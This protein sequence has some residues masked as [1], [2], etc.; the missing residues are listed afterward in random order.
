MGPFF[1][2]SNMPTDGPPS[3]AVR[4]NSSTLPNSFTA[5][6]EIQYDPSGRYQKSTTHI[7]QS[8]GIR[9][10]YKA[11]DTETALE[12][13]WQEY[14]GVSVSSMNAIEKSI[15][16]LKSLNHK[17]IIKYHEGWVDRKQKKVI[18]ITE[19][20]PTGRGSITNVR[21]FLSRNVK[22]KSSVLQ[23]WLDQ[24][25]KGLIF[26]HSCDPPWLHRDLRCENI[27][28]RSNIGQLKIG[29]LELG[30]F[31]QNSHPAEFDGTPGYMPPE[32]ITNRFEKLSDVYAF[33]M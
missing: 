29:G 30:V 7:E 28:I 21:R 17:H 16:T 1:F 19:A 4:S 14:W 26:L 11:F 6:E 33:G 18:F 32:L 15:E 2:L 24:I 13:A 31:M 9:H 27:Y 25:L 8:R 22:M 20:M 10:V 12:V 23:N 5:T 3:T